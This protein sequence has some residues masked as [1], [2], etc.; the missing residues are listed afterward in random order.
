MT[1]NFNLK[2]I[3]ENLTTVCS[4]MRFLYGSQIINL[5]K[6]LNIDKNTCKTSE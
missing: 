3:L 6:E 5:S 4:T 1:T 2:I